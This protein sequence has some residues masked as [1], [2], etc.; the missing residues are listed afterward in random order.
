MLIKATPNFKKKEQ[1]DIDEESSKSSYLFG[2]YID[3]G[4]FI[5]PNYNGTR[6]SF[7]FSIY[8]NEQKYPPTLENE[9]YI[10]CTDEIVQIGGGG[11][12]PSIQFDKNIKD[13]NCNSSDTFKNDLLCS[14]NFT[15]ITLEV[16]K[17]FYK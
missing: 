2:A 14:R 1:I 12:G 5:D 6:D 7:I 13:G 3:K 16:F 4:M 17:F 9:Y 10:R 15:I 8:P 11:Q